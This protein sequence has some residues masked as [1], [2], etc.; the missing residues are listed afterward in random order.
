MKFRLKQ[1]RTY[2]V[3]RKTEYDM[4]NPEGIENVYHWEMVIYKK[5][6]RVATAD[7]NS[8]IK[9]LNQLNG[10]ILKSYDLKL[11]DMITVEQLNYRVV[12]ILP[13]MYADFN[14]FVLELMKDE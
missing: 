5:T 7:P 11:G 10:K 8:A 14:E 9:V 12:E 6:L 4:K 2:Q 1:L 3:T 13:R